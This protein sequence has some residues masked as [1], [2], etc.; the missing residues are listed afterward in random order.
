MLVGEQ[1]KRTRHYQGVCK[2][3]LVQHMY[4]YIWY[5]G[6]CAI[7]VVHVMHVMWA[8]LGHSHLLCMPAVSNVV[9]TG[10]GMGT[11]NVLK[12]TVRFGL[13]LVSSLLSTTLLL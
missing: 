9:T 2:F 10:N 5:R 6:T 3:E 4:I 11:R 7:I 1:A 12:W 8:E 13:C